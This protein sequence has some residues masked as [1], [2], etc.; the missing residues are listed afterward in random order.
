M[1]GFHLRHACFILGQFSYK[2]KK[3]QKTVLIIINSIRQIVSELESSLF[4]LFRASHLPYRAKSEKC[5]ICSLIFIFLIFPIP[6]VWGWPYRAGYPSGTWAWT[7]WMHSLWS[8]AFFTLDWLTNWL[9]C[10]MAGVL[11]GWSATLAGVLTGWIHFRQDGFILSKV[12]PF[13]NYQF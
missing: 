5:S 12:D 9:E 11:T 7:P 1:Y 4:S 8:S 10:Q 2:I 3:I 13:C 6:P